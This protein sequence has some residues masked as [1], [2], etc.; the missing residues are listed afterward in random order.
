MS[1]VRGIQSA[2]VPVDDEIAAVSPHLD[3]SPTT[4]PRSGYGEVA[5]GIRARQRR[6]HAPFFTSKAAPY[7]DR[8]TAFARYT[9]ARGVRVAYHHHM[10]AYVEAPA[11]VD[12]LMSVVGDEVGLLFDSGHMTFAGGDAAAMLARHVKRVCHVHCKDVRPQVIGLARN[13]NWSFLQAVING[14]FDLAPARSTSGRCCSCWRDNLYAGWLVSKRNRIGRGTSYRYP[15][16]ATRLVSSHPSA[17]SRSIGVE[18]AVRLT[19]AAREIFKGITT[20]RRLIHRF[21]RV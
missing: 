11:D 16:Q 9:L 21:C 1:R 18:P 8:L 20:I 2:C 4:V 6:L 7:A 12:R 3:F 10:G 5:D 13:R 15:G 19:A 17:R 14:A